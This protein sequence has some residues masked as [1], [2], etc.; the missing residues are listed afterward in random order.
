M[1]SNHPNCLGG[2][3]PSA[4]SDLIGDVDGPASATDNAVA[5]F[6]G[7][8]G[9]LIQN[10]TVTI[11]DSTGA[12]AGASSLTS[13]AGNNLTLG[14][15]TLGPAITVIAAS[16]NV[17]I[18][19]TTPTGRLTVTAPSAIVASQESD[20]TLV[21]NSSSAAGT[22]I[23]SQM[24]FSGENGQAV[25][26]PF[27]F[28]TIAGRYEGSGYAGYL[29][30]STVNAAGT[31]SEKMRIT[32]TG[33][34][35]IGTTSPNVKLELG[36]G[37]ISNVEP[38]QYLRVNAGTYNSALSANLDLLC[39]GNNFTNSLGWRLSSV[40]AAGVSTARDLTFSS[41]VDGGSGVVGAATER[42]RIASA[43]GTVSIASST[44]GSASAG[45]L[46]VTG[47]LSAGNNGNASYFGGAVTSTGNLTLSDSDARIVGGTA[48]GRVIFGNAN[49]S[50]YVIAY[51]ISHATYPGYIVSV[52]NAG[53]AITTL[54]NTGLAVTGTLSTTGAA[55]F[56]GAVTVGA[57]TSAFNVGNSGQLTI[58]SNGAAT[59]TPLQISNTAQNWQMRL[60]GS[61]SA[62]WFY[63]VTG[64]SVPLILSS[65]GAATFAGTVSPQQATTAAA[66]AYVKGAIYFDTT[67]NKLRVGGATT[68]ETITSV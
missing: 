62:L 24:S 32:S 6:D 37:T 19:T 22:D 21:L 36:L 26:T 38:N 47:G 49:T 56:G 55:T 43:T 13:P 45:A 57:G 23:G 17:G 14:T 8:T 63:N 44:A 67:L 16:N 54:T 30:Y 15:G 48:A 65:S 34:V 27:A 25:A 2:N 1:L 52:A 4:S 60:N 53:S 64:G 31:L 41:L 61:N 3:G 12:I 42:M 59:D 39:W 33:N 10:S 46:V 20:R 18:G 51:G 28:G 7:T 58:A 40:N 11:A 29:Q 35:G 68:W 50:A 9:K 5:R 66:P